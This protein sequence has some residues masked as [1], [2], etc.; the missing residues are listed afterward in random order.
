MFIRVHPWLKI[1]SFVSLRLKFPPPVVDS[2]LM[3]MPPAPPE[4][5]WIGRDHLTITPD[6]VVIDAAQVMPD[7]QVRDYQ[8]MPIF[9]GESKFFLRQKIQAKKPFALRYVL[10]RWPEEASFDA[11]AFSLTYDEDYVRQRDAAHEEEKRADKIGMAMLWLYPVLGFLWAGTKKK[12]IPF[13]FISRSITGVSIFT[14]LC[15]MILQGT[16]LRMRLGLLTLLLGWMNL[17]ELL[18]LAL[19][20]ALLG[21][22]LVDSVLRFDQHLK[23]AEHP[24]G[25]GEWMTKPFQKKSLEE[26]DEF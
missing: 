4:S 10:E 5:L 8:R 23:G 1:L 3:E 14:G 19:D 9:L 17:P 20:Y 7:W 16:F 25:F 2:S 21:L 22:L 15:G 12:L 6:Q 26:E 13:G 11:A 24:W 18:L